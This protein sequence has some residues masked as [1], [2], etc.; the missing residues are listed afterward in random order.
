MTGLIRFFRGWVRFRVT[1]GFP[2]RFINLCAVKGLPLWNGQRRGE[3]CFFTTYA[4][5]YRRLK[6][7]ARGAGVT[8]RVTQRGG[9]PFVVYHRRNRW[10][11][12]VGAVACA[13][14]LAVSSQFLWNVRVVGNRQLQEQILLEQ[15]ETLGVKPGVLLKNIDVQ[16]VERRLMMELEE[17]GWVAVNLQGSTAVVQ[18]QERVMPPQ[19]LDRQTPCNVVAKRGGQIVSMQ[20][21][22]GQNMAKNGDAVAQGDIL[23]S[24]VV[25]DAAGDIH[26]VPAR[27]DIMAKTN[28][29]LQTQ[30]PLRQ[31]R[32]ALQRVVRRFSLKLGSLEIPLWVGKPPA[33][34]FRL[35]R[36]YTPLRLLGKELPVSLGKRQYLILRQE[37]VSLTHRQ[38]EQEA[39]RRLA[40]LEQESF[41]HAT[42]LDCRCQ[43]QNTPHSVVLSADYILLENIS[44]Q[45]EIFTAHTED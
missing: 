41:A 29:T 18:V 24:G 15:L 5:L 16:R 9:L 10:G 7:C 44:L 26:L 45:S 25:E 27:A 39:Q 8:L 42:V 3:V 12:A 40:L 14:L 32:Y 34:Q 36:M 35:E 1:G 38:A 21:Y 11:L 22:V 33:G 43:T 28:H 23:V 2:E 30:V 17:L 13:V 31:N 20:V 6:P 37:N 19:M 4:A